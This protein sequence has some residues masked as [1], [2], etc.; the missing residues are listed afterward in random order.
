MKN[1]IESAKMIAELLPL[2]GT[3]QYDV[4]VP[5]SGGKDGIWILSLLSNIPGLRIL[6]VHIDN[7]FISSV[8]QQNIKRAAEYIDFDLVTIR[9][10]WKTLQDVYRTFVM[11]LGEICIPCE[12]MISLCPIE[13]AAS[14]R[15]PT[16]VWGLTPSQLAQKRILNGTDRL[17]FGKY[18]RIGQYYRQLIRSAY[19]QQSRTVQPAIEKL[20]AGHLLEQDAFPVYFFP[21][22][23]TGYDAAI[24][25]EDVI[26]CVG[27]E[28]ANDVG[29][30]SSN[31][32]INQ[33]HILLKKM[34]HGE[35]FYQ[36]MIQAKL[37][38]S[39]VIESVAEGAMHADPDPIVI[40]E[41]L[42]KLQIELELPEL[43]RQINDLKKDVYLQIESNI[44]R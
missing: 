17:D 7:W 31:C 1:M 39:E 43:V 21:F 29:G 32:V 3:G 26:R 13:V 25:E 33:L 30:T 6:G 36:D 5:V 40:K 10:N 24:I 9:P 28:R 34:R 2:A 4:L 20:F 35:A 37:A 23:F 19:K 14:C 11:G 12:G 41:L 16:V 42:Q 22:H 44:S 15:I 18:Q 8:A 38:A 27:W